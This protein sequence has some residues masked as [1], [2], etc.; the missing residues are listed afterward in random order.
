MRFV[1][2]NQLLTWQCISDLTVI[3]ITYQCHFFVKENIE[4]CLEIKSPKHLNLIKNWNLNQVS[5]LWCKC[6]WA[7]FLTTDPMRW[8]GA[9]FAFVVSV[10]L[11]D[12]WIVL[13]VLHRRQPCVIWM[14]LIVWTAILRHQGL[15]LT[16]WL[17]LDS[18]MEVVILMRMDISFRIR[19][20]AA[21]CALLTCSVQSF[22]RIFFRVDMQLKYTLW[23]VCF[24]RKISTISRTRR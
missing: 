23:S 5:W 12:E 9:T 20:V 6:Y 21:V 15:C 19:Q 16:S 4:Q 22:V 11:Q 7:D 17:V 3:Q 1:I 8:A 14:A 24:Y 18:R 13:S 2:R 10:L